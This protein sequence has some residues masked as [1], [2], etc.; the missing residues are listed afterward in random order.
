MSRGVTGA[1]FLFAAV[2]ATP[3]FEAAQAAEKSE[4][5]KPH[6]KTPPPGTRVNVT[7][8]RLVYDARR[9]IA[10]ATGDVYITYGRYVLVARKVAYDQRRDSLRADGEVRLLEPGGNIL[11][12]DIAQLQN[13]FRDGFAEHLRLLLTNDA[14]M[15][16]DYAKRSDGNLTIYTKVAY[17]RCKD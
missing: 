13:K 11:E 7:A 1:V 15:T 9:K 10:V 14:R 2:L 4:R 17:T 6:L 16:A 12:A 3:L 5:L 8:N